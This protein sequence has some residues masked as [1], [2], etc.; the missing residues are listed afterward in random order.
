MSPILVIVFAPVIAAAVALAALLL[1]AAA[2]G[3]WESA[4]EHARRESPAVGPLRAPTASRNHESPRA[5][6]A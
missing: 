4:E 2:A 3:A 1:G 6:A 5:R